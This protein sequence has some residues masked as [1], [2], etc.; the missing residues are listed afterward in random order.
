MTEET[1]LINGAEYHR[2]LFEYAPIS[3]WEEDYSRVKAHLESLRAQGVHDLDAYLHTQPETI[4]YCMGLVRVLDVNR[5]TLEMFKAGSKEELIANLDKVFRDDMAQH[6]ALELLN[7]WGGGARFEGNGI[8]YALDGSEV[9]IHL[10]WTALPGYEVSL[11][12]VL[13]SLEDIGSQLQ[14]EQALIESEAHFHGLFEN[15]PISLW[16]EDF[17]WVKGYLEGL[18]MEGVEDLDEYLEAHPEAVEEC[19]GLIRVL[20]VN[21]KVLEMLK[22]DSK[23]HLLKNLNTVF[24][25]EMGRHFRDQLLDMW[26]GLY[27]HEREGINYALDGEEIFIRLRWAVMPGYEET[28]GRVLVSLEDITARKRAEDYLRYLGTHDVLTGLY[29]R[30]YFEEERN[31]LQ[32][33]RLYPISIVIID[34]DGLKDVNDSRGHEAGDELLRRAAEVFKASFRNEDVV[35][36]LGGDEFGVILPKTDEGAVDL[37]M[38]RVHNLNDMSN[39]FYPGAPLNFSM[40]AATAAIGRMLTE[41]QRVADDHMYV[42]KRK[43]RRQQNLP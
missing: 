27:Y 35:A 32:N 43:H 37:A 2:N 14:A 8:N 40:G 15:A 26:N 6:Y 9:H 1:T 11:E 29:N 13:V 30:A 3:L 22:A 4:A 28:L 18:R 19:M 21:Y 33:S 24:Q 16:E 7:I 36:R 5:C 39:N 31:R 10:H 38:Q 20:D 34:L 42:E 12:R 23:E 41:V 25:G 17:S